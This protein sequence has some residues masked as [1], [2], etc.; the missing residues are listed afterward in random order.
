L[1]S[2]LPCPEIFFEPR[3]GD[4]GFCDARD[5]WGLEAAR[6][7]SRIA[8]KTAMLMFTMYSSEQLLREAH[9]AGIKDV[10]SKSDEVVDHLLASLSNVC[11]AP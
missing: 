5:E 9:A 10:L 11:V 2:P 7:I 4:L 1:G 6:Q 3:R 8:P